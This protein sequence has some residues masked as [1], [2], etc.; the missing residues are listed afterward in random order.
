VADVRTR[1]GRIKPVQS[2]VPVPKME[3]TLVCSPRIWM[4]LLKGLR[5]NGFADVKEIGSQN[6]FQFLTSCGGG[7]FVCGDN[8]T[9]CTAEP[10]FV[11]SSLNPGP[12]RQVNITG[13]STSSSSDSG[14]TS[15]TVL[16]PAQTSSTSP[17]SNNHSLAVGV[18]VGIPL[19]VALVSAIAWALWERSKRLKGVGKPAPYPAEV[20]SSGLEYYSV[21]NGTK[22]PIIRSEL[23][24]QRQPTHEQHELQ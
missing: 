4:A 14:S 23:D 16:P 24:G 18:G 5:W 7:D 3:S 17:S 12:I 9:V 2:F 8:Q 15:D 19:A 20:A 10:S 1:R 11:L 13:N 21:K 6:A 22:E